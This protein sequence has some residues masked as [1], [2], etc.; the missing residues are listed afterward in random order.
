[1]ILTRDTD[2]HRGIAPAAGFCD[3]DKERSSED[4]LDSCFRRN[5]RAMGGRFRFVLS[6]LQMACGAPAWGVQR[7]EAPL[8]YSLPPRVG[9]H[10]GLEEVCFGALRMASRSASAAP[11]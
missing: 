5:D 10:R 11:M 9:D 2:K 3:H 8:R 1:M 4:V 6:A 7:G